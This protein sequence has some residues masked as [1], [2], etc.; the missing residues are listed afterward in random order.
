[1]AVQQPPA[2][3]PRTGDI[4]VHGRE[5]LSLAVQFK[6]AD[7]S[8]R[9]VSAA[10]LFFEVDTLLRVALGAGASNDKRTIT[11]TREQIAQLAGGSHLFALID[12]TNPIPDVVW[13]GQIRV[14]GYTVQPA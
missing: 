8:L 13:R 3:D 4:V 9:D 5:G 11:V 6:L 14:E 1:M 12:E 10:A 2:V 7:G